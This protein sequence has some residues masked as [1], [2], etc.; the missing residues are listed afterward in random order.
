MKFP[1]KLSVITLLAGTSLLLQGCPDNNNKINKTFSIEVTNLTNAQPF[2]PAGA[3][4]HKAGYHAYILGNQAST[5]LEELAEGGDNSALLTAAD[6]DI[7][8]TA[9]ASGS[10][11]IAPGMSEVFQIK[12]LSDEFKLSLVS[13]LV[14]TNDGFI[15]SDAVDISTLAKDGSMTLLVDVY[16]AGTEANDEAGASLP[17]QGGEGFNATRDDRDFVAVHPGIVSTSDGLT[18]SA[19]DSSHRFDNP[20]ARI[21][22]TRIK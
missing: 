16:D 4:L 9:T 7:N 5:A 12:G 18:T 2:S 10:G 19:L 3:V 20:A 15:G 17:G 6:A 14:N 1:M 8:V 22:V 11:I 13:M 21:V